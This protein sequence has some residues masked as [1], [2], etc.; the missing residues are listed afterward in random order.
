MTFRYPTPEDIGLRI[1][2]NLRRERFRR[3]FDHGLRGGQ[4]D[5]IDYFRLSFRLGF[6]FAKL[7]L[8]EVRRHRGILQ[9]PMRARFRQHTIW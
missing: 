1:P 6:R 9:L 3:G 5:R 7:Y 2:P 4:L 8:R